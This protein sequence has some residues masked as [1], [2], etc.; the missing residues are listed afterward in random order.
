MSSK[1]G[2]K[3]RKLFGGKVFAGKTSRKYP[4]Q[5]GKTPVTT[6]GRSDITFDRTITRGLFTVARYGT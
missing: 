1:A 4:C 6:S 5:L 3:E 2:G